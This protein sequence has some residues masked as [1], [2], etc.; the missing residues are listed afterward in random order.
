M[1]AIRKVV[2]VF[3]VY[4]I[5]VFFGLLFTFLRITGR[6]KITGRKNL[7]PRHGRG[8]FVLSNH[9]SLVDVCL[10]VLCFPEVLL[11]PITGL[12]WGAIDH[13]NLRAPWLFWMRIFKLVPIEREL[14]SPNRNVAA[15]AKMREMLSAGEAVILFPEG[16][17][18]AK[19]GEEKR[20]TSPITRRQI[21]RFKGGITKILSGIDCDVVLIWIEGADTVLPVGSMIPLFWRSSITFHVGEP[22]GSDFSIEEYED[23]MLAL[24]DKS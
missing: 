13:K 4:T 12:P 6:I 14:I 5:G 7:F 15:V 24:A 21:G 9:I 10:P 8:R 23:A 16:T 11:H 20:K 17:R 3:G 1:S 2:L 18:L 19:V 22:M